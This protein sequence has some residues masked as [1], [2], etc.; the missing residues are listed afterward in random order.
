M[1]VNTVG[2]Y[3]RIVYNYLIGRVGQ[4]MSAEALKRGVR[5]NQQCILR[6]VRDYAMMP[7]LENQSMAGYLKDQAY[8]SLRTVYSSY[9]VKY[10]DLSLDGLLEFDKD[11]SR[12][13]K[14]EG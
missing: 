7:P 14:A 8:I 2:Y 12:L 1:A 6:I 9:L 10:S 11:I 5:Q 13:D 3:P 4:T